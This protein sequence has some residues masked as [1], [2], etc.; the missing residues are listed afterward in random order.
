[1]QSPL[2][3]FISCSYNRL[4]QSHQQRQQLQTATTKPHKRRK[5]Y[6]N[7]NNLPI[8]SSRRPVS[9]LF[10]SSSSALIE[11]RLNCKIYWYQFAYNSVYSCELVS[12]T[13]A[14]SFSSIQIADTPL[15]MYKTNIYMRYMLIRYT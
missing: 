6:N 13:D 3:W 9:V 5:K 14:A 11:H 2:K 7:N 12:V 1:M 8:S 15:F 10:F 4:E